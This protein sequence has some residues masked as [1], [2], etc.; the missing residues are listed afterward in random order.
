MFQQIKKYLNALFAL[1]FSFSL[2][3]MCVLLEKQQRFNFSKEHVLDEIINF[4][5]LMLLHDETIKKI[6]FLDTCLCLKN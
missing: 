1:V 3:A 2:N 6:I 4:Q 5:L